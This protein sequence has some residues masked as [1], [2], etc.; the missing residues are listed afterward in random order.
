MISADNVNATTVTAA[1]IVN[2]SLARLLKTKC[3]RK[4]SVLML[5]SNAVTRAAKKSVLLKTWIQ[6][7]DKTA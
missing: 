2:C 4:K 3:Y 1:R 7:A 6:L 5:A